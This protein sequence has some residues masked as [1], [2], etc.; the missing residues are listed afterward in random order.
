VAVF[1]PR[2]LLL[3]VLLAPVLA[4]LASWMPAL[5]AARQDPAVT[6]QEG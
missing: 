1:E 3:T 4:A 5:L 6:L 2:W